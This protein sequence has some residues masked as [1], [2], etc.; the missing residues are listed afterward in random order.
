MMAWCS[1]TLPLVLTNPCLLPHLA[2]MARLKG[3]QPLGSWV[4]SWV[5]LAGR[6]AES[7]IKAQVLLKAENDLG[8]NS[9]IKA[10]RSVP[11]GKRTPKDFTI[12]LRYPQIS[13]MPNQQQIEKNPHPA[14][15]QLLAGKMSSS[16]G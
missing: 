3:L 11:Q 6:Q 5:V 9:H 16:P 7:Q 12:T 10:M 14:Q 15:V 4:Q 8:L 2:I 1:R 13:C